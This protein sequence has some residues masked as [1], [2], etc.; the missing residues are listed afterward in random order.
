MFRDIKAEA[1]LSFDNKKF[2]YFPGVC[3]QATYILANHGVK[4]N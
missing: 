4:L 1:R 3:N 2:M